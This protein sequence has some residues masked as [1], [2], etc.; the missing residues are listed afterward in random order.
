[1]TILH[2]DGMDLLSLGNQRAYRR[3]NSELFPTLLFFLN[4]SGVSN[5]PYVVIFPKFIRCVATCEEG[6]ETQ[7]D[8]ASMIFLFYPNFMAFDSIHNL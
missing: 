6:S 4:E 8:N 1:V 3:S 5:S 2:R 7:N